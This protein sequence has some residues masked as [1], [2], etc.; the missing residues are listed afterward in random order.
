[1]SD[2][3]CANDVNDCIEANLDVQ[4]IMAV[5]Q[6][7]STVFYYWTGSDVWLSWISTVADME[8]PPDVFSISYG[9]YESTIPSSYLSA[10]NTEA[11]KLGVLG[12]TLLAA[13]GDDGVGG[14]LVRRGDT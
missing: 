10:F 14:F 6:N 2:S 12:T 1:V 3:A 7:V 5:A 11:I 8:D 9:S 4:Y 13:T